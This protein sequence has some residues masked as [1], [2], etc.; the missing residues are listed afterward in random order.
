M[1]LYNAA[2]AYA[3]KQAGLNGSNTEMACFLNDPC[4]NGAVGGLSGM[5]RQDHPADWKEPDYGFSCGNPQSAINDTRQ[6]KPCFGEV[7][8]CGSD[9]SPPF[10]V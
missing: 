5:L 2:V 9:N 6:K 8:S 4:C 10:C 1:E 3:D 7:Y